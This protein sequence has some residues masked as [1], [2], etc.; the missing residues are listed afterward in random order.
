VCEAKECDLGCILLQFQE[1][2]RYYLPQYHLISPRVCQHITQAS[3]SVLGDATI[4][5]S[6]EE[7]KLTMGPSHNVHYASLWII[8]CHDHQL[9]KLMPLHVK[10]VLF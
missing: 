8:F 2:T 10:I 6:H 1:S 5:A 7:K 3:P 4:W 9:E